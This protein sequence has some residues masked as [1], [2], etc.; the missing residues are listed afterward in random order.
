MNFI[1]M[2]IAI[3]FATNLFLIGYPP[4]MLRVLNKHH[5]A[6]VLVYVGIV[7]LIQ[8]FGTYRTYVSTYLSKNE[9]TIHNTFD[10]S[11]ALNYAKVLDLAYECLQ[12]SYIPL[13]K[14]I[15]IYDVSYYA[16]FYALS[17][18]IFLCKLENFLLG[19]CCHSF[20]FYFRCIF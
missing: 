8:M 13:C 20:T 14:F 19:T 2:R 15:K 16:Y 18:G 17:K 5:T 6:A 11:K 10:Y 4:L 3:S 7:L 9:V 1:F 12:I